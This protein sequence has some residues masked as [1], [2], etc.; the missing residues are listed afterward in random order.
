MAESIFLRA[1]VD[2]VI[3]GIAALSFL[4]CVRKRKAV[5]EAKATYGFMLIS[6]GLIA[7]GLFHLADLL[8]VL[9]GRG[10]AASETP[11]L[12]YGRIATLVGTGAVFAGF[13][14]LKKGLLSQLRKSR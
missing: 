5:A 1:G 2:A 10:A 13:V 8:A 6:A 12:G 9:G 3:V 11:G 4:I 7:I 14:W